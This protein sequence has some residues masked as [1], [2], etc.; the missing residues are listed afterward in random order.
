MSGKKKL[1]WNDFLEYELLKDKLDAI[2]YP[3]LESVKQV[4]QTWYMKYKEKD[5]PAGDEIWFRLRLLEIDPIEDKDDILI[6]KKCE[7]NHRDCVNYL[8]IL[9]EKGRKTTGLVDPEEEYSE[10]MGNIQLASKEELNITSLPGRPRY[11]IV[12]SNRGITFIGPSPVRDPDAIIK[13]P[14]KIT[15]AFKKKLKSLTRSLNKPS[16]FVVVPL[17]KLTEDREIVEYYFPTVWKAIFDRRDII[18]DFFQLF[19][20]ARS[21]LYDLYKNHEITGI[22]DD[23]EIGYFIDELMLQLLIVWYLQSKGFLP[24]G[25]E[26][27][28]LIEKFLEVKDKGEYSYFEFLK[29]LFKVMM[30]NDEECAINDEN[31]FAECPDL[32]RVFI[33]G[34]APF[35][36]SIEKLDQVK[37]PNKAFYFST[38]KGLKKGP[39]YLVTEKPKNLKEK[40]RELGE[41]GVPVLAIFESRDWTSEGAEGEIDRYVIGAIFEKLLDPEARK[42]RGAYYTPEEITKYIAENTINPYL[43]DRLN[44]EFETEYKTLD[45][46]FNEDWKRNGTD[47]SQKER[48]YILLFNELRNLKI[49]DPAV[50]SGHFLESAIEVL[51]DIYKQIRNAVIDYGFNES[52]FAITTVDRNGELVK[53][54]ITELKAGDE[55]K[56]K[57]MFYIII[58]SNIY[59]VDIDPR[60]VSLTRARLFLTLAESFD[61]TGVYIRFPNV[62]FNIRPGNSLIGFITVEELYSLL[63][64]EEKGKLDKWLTFSKPASKT[65]SPKVN[66]SLQG[67]TKDYIERI[68]EKLKNEPEFADGRS[69]VNELRKLKVSLNTQLTKELFKRFLRLKSKLMRI[70]LVSL[71]TK[72][73]QEIIKLLDEMT[74]AVNYN[75]NQELAESIVESLKDTIKM[76]VEDLKGQLDDLS[77]I[78]SFHWPWEFP[79]VFMRENPGFDIVIGN[80]PYIASAGR[81]GISASIDSELK[82]LLNLLYS[83]AK[84]Q[85]DIFGIFVERGLAITRK[86]GH[87]GFILPDSILVREHHMHLREFILKNSRI[88]TIV[89]LGKAFE[90]AE[91]TNAIILLKRT[92]VQD[93]YKFFGIYCPLKYP[94]NIK[95]LNQIDQELTAQGKLQQ[96]IRTI[97]TKNIE[98]M[99][100]LE[101]LINASSTTFKILSYLL[102]PAFYRLSDVAK[103]FRG[104]EIGKR[105]QVLFDEHVKN[106]EPILAG[107]DFTRYCLIKIDKFIPREKIKKDIH[108]YQKRKILLRQTSD[109]IQGVY[110][111]VG[112]V[113]IKSVYCVYQDAD[114]GKGIDIKA[115]YFILNSSVPTWF[116]KEIFGKYKLAYPQINQSTLLMVPVPPHIPPITKHIGEY[117]SMLYQLSCGTEANETHLSTIKEFFEELGES[118]VYWM[119][120]YRTIENYKELSG[121]LSLIENQLHTINYDRWAELYWKKHLGEHLTPEDEKELE[122]LEKENMETIRRVYKNLK[123]D[124]R[125]TMWIKKIKS[126]NWV[127]TIESSF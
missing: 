34:P 126:H 19:R 40:M 124:E 28:Y 67:D 52:E 30:G 50:G 107:E 112:V 42:G 85:Y 86:E 111:P 83:T 2:G 102:S 44:E 81:T 48:Q 100:K 39:D 119:Y 101:F 25:R 7:G 127:R 70:L 125:V 93:S 60:A 77:K 98:R 45:D 20:L 55:F 16:K 61:P 108:R 24:E 59:G 57:I 106:T 31:T 18:E 75:L 23:R 78:G 3:Q 62:H 94:E 49:I 120:F 43:I 105:A 82:E 118:I 53:V 95:L 87:F 104:E 51:V 63:T 1:G 96:Y 6:I 113:A 58:S 9:L 109:R 92:N 5:I 33:T 27:P 56:L 121:T 97:D 14:D 88:K 89:Q 41:E 90:N 38:P 64:K 110:D 91:T 123:K 84:G 76:N 69:V 10:L 116:Y 4:W 65:G 21:Y 103:V 11:A 80:P 122:K 66:L 29:R 68:E 79:E 36:T 13:S 15:E 46:F 8:K 26:K 17:N 73:A 117:I 54:P 22:T 32:G 71:D 114:I 12:F 35:L 99:P 37:I 72:Y 115:L 47:K 74:N